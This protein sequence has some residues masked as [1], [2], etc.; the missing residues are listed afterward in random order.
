[1]IQ[2][3]QRGRRDASLPGNV[4]DT[5]LLMEGHTVRLRSW[6][7]ATPISQQANDKTHGLQAETLIDISI[8]PNTNNTI[9]S[10]ALPIPTSQRGKGRPG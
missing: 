4:V 8:N 9:V 7:A 10:C 2:Q 1:M 5:M 6:P 3:T